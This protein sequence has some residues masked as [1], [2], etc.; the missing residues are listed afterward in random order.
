MA[1][2][3]AAAGSYGRDY[4]ADFLRYGLAFVGGDANVAAIGQ[5]QPGDRVILKRGRSQVLAVGVAIE[6]NGVCAGN[7]DKRWL[8]D[9]DGWGLLGYCNVEWHCPPTPHPTTGLTR[10]SFQGVNHA[11][12][13]TL[14]DEAIR[15]WIVAAAPQPEPGMTRD[16]TDDQIIEV[17]VQEGLRPA[18]AGELTTALRRIR[19][20]TRYYKSVRG[21]DVNES[22][23]RTFLVAPFF[24]ALGWPEQH[25]KLELNIT[26]T[27]RVDLACFKRPYRR[28]EN[29]AF[30]ADDCVLLVECKG[31]GT[32]LDYAHVQGKQYAR[33]YP[34]AKAVV[35]TNGYC[36][37]VY[38][39]RGEDFDEYP[40]AYLNLTWPQHR[41]PR[42]PE[43]VAGAVDVLKL[44][45]PGSWR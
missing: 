36:Y 19:L 15:D 4:S 43:R 31:F 40:A 28:G 18:A 42:D 38:P 35:A 7:G 33:A 22:E 25:V 30:N 29:R 21:S 27:G 41:Y 8:S 12:L 13:Q 23:V 2:W 1:Y 45:L 44:L 16:V 32:G 3:Q 9:Y 6:R 17:L 39:R 5:V 26:G 20:L 11:H 24:L 34:T 10:T 14:A 37:K